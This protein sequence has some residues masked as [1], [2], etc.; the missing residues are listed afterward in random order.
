MLCARVVDHASLVTMAAALDE[1]EVAVPVVNLLSDLAHPCQA[2]ADLLTLGDVFGT[3]SLG[4]LTVAYIGDANN[5]WRS[6]A[7][8]ASMCGIATRIAAPAGHGPTP[9]DVELVRS[10]GGELTVT[11]DPAEAVA[12][13]DAIYTDV[14][15]SMGQEEERAARLAAF[16]GF[17]VDDGPGVQGGGPCRRP[18]LPSGPPGRGDQRRG[19]RRA[20]QRGV[21]DRPAIGCTPCAACWPG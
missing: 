9:A 21:A 17:T 4:R 10:F 18:P 5:V 20:A 1:A 8:A 14:W 7:I 13:V 15:T 12:G 19:R 11:S 2:V 6:L 3:G 16:A